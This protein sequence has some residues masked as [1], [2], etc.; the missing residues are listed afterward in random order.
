M[1]RLK[2]MSFPMV[3]ALLLTV[4]VSAN[5]VLATYAQAEQ[6]FKGLVMI[7]KNKAEKIATQGGSDGGGKM[8]F[9]GISFGGGGGKGVKDPLLNVQGVYTKGVKFD[10]TVGIMGNEAREVAV[11]GAHLNLQGVMVLR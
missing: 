11:D 10:A 1:E 5:V 3:L 4:S 8:S 9:L 6:T 7:S 2:D